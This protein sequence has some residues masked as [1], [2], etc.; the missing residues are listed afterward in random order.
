MESPAIVIRLAPVRETDLMVTLLTKDL[1]TISAVAKGAKQSKRRFMG[2]LDIFDCGR[3][4]FTSLKEDFYRLESLRSKQDFSALGRNLAAF[5]LAS[6]GIEMVRTFAPVGDSQGAYFFQPLYSLLKNLCSSP[7]LSLRVSTWVYFTLVSY[8]LSGLDYFSSEKDLPENFLV[9]TNTMLQ[10]R[11]AFAPEDKSIL[12][13]VVP[14]LL[15][16]YIECTGTKVM[17]HEVVINSLQG[18]SKS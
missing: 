18:L 12:N 13:E 14:S 7:D 6:C 8:K 3:F 4:T 5:S 9:W 1:G 17:T 15:D 11:K 16:H 2:G 10:Q